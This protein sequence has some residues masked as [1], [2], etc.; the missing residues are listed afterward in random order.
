MDNVNISMIYR[1]PNSKLDIFY[2]YLEKLLEHNGS[3]EAAFFGDFN[4]DLKKKSNS[5]LLSIYKKYG[6]DLKVPLN[7][8]STENESQIDLCFSNM[9][10]ARAWY[11]ETILCLHKPICITWTKDRNIDNALE[12]MS[13]EENSTIPMDTTDENKIDESFSSGECDE[14]DEEPENSTI[15]MDTN[16]ENK[17]DESVPSREYD[18]SDESD[19]EPDPIEN[20]IIF[21]DGRIWT[22]IEIKSDGNCLFRALSHQMNGHQNFHAFYRHQIVEHIRR[23]RMEFENFVDIDGMSFD[24]YCNSMDTDKTHGGQMEI[25]AFQSIYGVSIKIHRWDGTLGTYDAAGEIRER[26]LNLYFTIPN[27]TDILAHYESLIP[28]NVS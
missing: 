1:H 15:P 17:I 7:S 12:K 2:Q 13:I 19:E 28:V 8:S 26:V 18:E 3:S 11:Y 21:S 20:K 25:I 5:I 14:S 10:S 4:I 9:K 24:E 16:N 23:N 6:Y 27:N 22:K